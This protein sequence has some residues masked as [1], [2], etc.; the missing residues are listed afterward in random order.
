[1]PH[2]IFCGHA[3][4]RVESFTFPELAAVTNYRNRLSHESVDDLRNGVN[5]A[6]VSHLAAHIMMSE[7]CPASR[8][9]IAQRPRN[10]IAVRWHMLLASEDCELTS[11]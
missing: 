1:M 3:T 4:I 8:M 2:E 5:R 6:S 7:R 9:A 10:A 11:I